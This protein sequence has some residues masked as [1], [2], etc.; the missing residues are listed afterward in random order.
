[1]GSKSVFATFTSIDGS[2]PF[3]VYADVSWN[4][5]FY[6]TVS[7]IYSPNL[8]TG[9]YK[10]RIKGRGTNTSVY[11]GTDEGNSSF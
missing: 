4:N 6:V 3:Y 9:Y 8:S 5:N 1:M 7:N 10:W 2:G 11:A